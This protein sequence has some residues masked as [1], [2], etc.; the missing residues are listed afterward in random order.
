M[1]KYKNFL[2]K[3][4]CNFDIT[5]SKSLESLEDL[6]ISEHFERKNWKFLTN[7]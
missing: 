2:V 6:S 7:L 4:C 5:D 3:G 1:E